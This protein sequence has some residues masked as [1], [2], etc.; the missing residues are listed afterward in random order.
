[1]SYIWLR[2]KT[3]V[4]VHRIYISMPPMGLYNFMRNS[5]WAWSFIL[6]FYKWWKCSIFHLSAALNKLDGDQCKK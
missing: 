3:G 1:M 4:A 2:L 6:Q 5:S